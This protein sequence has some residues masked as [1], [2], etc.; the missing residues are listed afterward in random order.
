VLPGRYTVR[1][2]VGE[3]TS[4]GT[5]D[6]VQDPR[7]NRPVAELAQRLETRLAGEALLAELRAAQDRL[8]RARATLERAETELRRPA[9]ASTAAR[10][11]LI[12]RT[13]LATARA[14][15]LLDRLRMAPGTRGIAQDSTVTAAVMAA[16]GRATG[17]PDAP[18]PG[19]RTELE[20]AGSRARGVVAEIDGFLAGEVEA[21]RAALR[22]AGVDG[23]GG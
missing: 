19:Q 17:S 3:H 15:S 4:T 20:W 9:G 23:L 14:D 7:T 16:L 11:S 1:V 18:T 13:R 5:L 22:A 2:T 21:L 10:D 12:E 8:E 6:V